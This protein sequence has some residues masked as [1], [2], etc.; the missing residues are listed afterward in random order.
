MYN[1][2]GLQRNKDV[3]VEAIA[4]YATQV[5]KVILIF[6]PSQLSLNIKYKCITPSNP[7]RYNVKQI[8]NLNKHYNF[9]AKVTIHPHLLCR[10]Y[11]FIIVVV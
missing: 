11:L 10:V 5:K 8:S 7:A 2:F 3:F 4:K 1:N 9:K 6:F